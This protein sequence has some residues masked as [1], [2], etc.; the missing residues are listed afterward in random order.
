MR[1]G[2]NARGVWPMMRPMS[3]SLVEFLVARFSADELRRLVQLN[4]PDLDGQLPEPPTPPLQMADALASL[5]ARHGR[6]DATFLGHLEVERPNC[7]AEVRLL[8]QA[9]DVSKAS[10]STES[11][12]AGSQSAPGRR[13]SKSRAAKAAY[14]WLHLTDIHFGCRGRAQWVQVVDDFEHSLNEWLGKIGGP[15]DLVLVSGD[16]TNR[17]LKAEFDGIS[18]FFNRVLD[19][20]TRHAGTRPLLIAVPGN[21]DLVRPD[22]DALLDY[23]AYDRYT[24]VGDPQGLRLHD[25]LWTRK[26][27]DRIASL[28]AEYSHWMDA[29]MLPSLAARAPEVQ[30]HRSFF[31][32]DLTVVVTLP[33]RFPLAIVGLNSAWLQYQGGDL[34][35][36]LALPAAQFQ[37][38]LP[39]P[40]GHMP[41]DFFRD[42]RQA[43]LMHHH[44]RSWLSSLYRD[45]HN[46]A[47]YVP[48]RFA[49]CLFGH[50][51]T[52]AAERVAVAG[53]EER[54]YFQTPSLFG[55]EYFGERNESRLF[56]YAFGRIQEDGE[57]RAWPLQCVR[58]YDGENRFVRD[59]GFHWQDDRYVLLR[60]GV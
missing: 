25:R 15:I 45:V 11:P 58:S 46:G 59:M 34:E 43:L 56:G 17:G 42:V 36:K 6:L 35:G 33:G 41:L 10:R 55:L 13:A 40:P 5:L 27:P 44:P 49:A 21:H 31:P 26:D 18:T 57:V 9:M 39:C 37:A 23:A 22:N 14:R 19:R 38:A 12:I 3:R 4:Y 2:L 53:G 28:F 48:R 1:G 29:Y 20:L 54:V 30:I 8:A 50:M 7:L 32:G 16:L 47:I 51:H 60:S 52:A 24:V